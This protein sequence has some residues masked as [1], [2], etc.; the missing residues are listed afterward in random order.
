[1]GAAFGSLAADL[2]RAK[3]TEFGVPDREQQAR[4][5]AGLTA[6]MDSAQNVGH[7]GDGNQ[8]EQGRLIQGPP[9]PGRTQTIGA[10]Q[11]EQIQAVAG[12]DLAG[13]FKIA[14]ETQALN[15]AEMIRQD[16]LRDTWEDNRVNRENLSI[17]QLNQKRAE[18]QWQNTKA[19][20]DIEAGKTPI[21]RRIEGIQDKGQDAV[22]DDGMLKYR[23]LFGTDE[24]QEDVGDWLATVETVETLNHIMTLT[25]SSVGFDPASIHVA[26]LGAL[27]SMAQTELRLGDQM[28]AAQKA[29][30][31][32]LAARI[33]DASD[34]GSAI[35]RGD[36]AL[37]RSLGVLQERA[38]RRADTK[39][40][41]IDHYDLEGSDRVRAATAVNLAPQIRQSAFEQADQRAQE[42][43]A[44]VP[45][46]FA[47]DT[48]VGAAL[49]A[50]TSIGAEEGQTRE[51]R[52]KILRDVEGRSDAPLF[53]PEM[54]LRG[55]LIQDPDARAAARLLGDKGGDFGL[56]AGAGIF[57]SRFGLGRR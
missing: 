21:Q 8:D 9:T 2:W 49:A 28:G 44:Q 14:R 11:R 30:M 25:A 6:F 55:P 24:H 12:F 31:E 37:L 51:D 50:L 23:P 48:L 32:Q 20:Q 42:F 40:K 5:R 53:L 10:Q 22:F 1:M 4:E 17:S 18:A 34:L 13:A 47:N 35:V 33:P 56:G 7:P 52:L 57:L 19:L 39:T 26:T 29:E 36:P 16:N 38:A 54:R 15:R 45:A 27:V 3:L 46:T 43:A 41:S